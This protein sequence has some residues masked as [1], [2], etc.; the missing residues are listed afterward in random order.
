MYSGSY[1]INSR[2]PDSPG[3]RYR[4]TFPDIPTLPVKVAPVW[5]YQLAPPQWQQHVLAH[6]VQILMTRDQPLEGR[7][8]TPTWLGEHL[9]EPP[10][11]TAW[12]EVFAEV[13]V[14]RARSARSRLGEA[15]PLVLAPVRATVRDTNGVTF[16]LVRD[17]VDKI[18]AQPAYEHFA[19]E[20]RP[21]TIRICFVVDRADVPYRSDNDGSRDQEEFEGLERVGQMSH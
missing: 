14:T 5:K 13:H 18:M 2:F 7:S 4:H 3:Q 6:M 1:Q 21:V 16:G 8:E 11:S 20:K 12:I 9:A 10:I 19:R 15:Y 17:A